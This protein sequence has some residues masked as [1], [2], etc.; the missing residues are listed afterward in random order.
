[1]IESNPTSVVAGFDMLLEE[2]GGKIDFVNR[3]GARAFERRDCDKA[4][5]ALE[6]AAQVTGFRDKADALPREWENFFAR[7]EDEEGTKAHAARR[8]LG[9][10]RRGLR[11]QEKAYYLPILEALQ[12]LGGSAPM[13]HRFSSACFRA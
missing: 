10:L 3:V 13:G 6:R 1:M 11:T 2:I 12:A 4:K 8:N 5:E 7:E 9:R